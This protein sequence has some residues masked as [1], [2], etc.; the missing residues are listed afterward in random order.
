MSTTDLK[1]NTENEIKNCEV[2]RRPITSK[3]LSIGFLVSDA[4]NNIFNLE[5]G[6]LYTLIELFRNPKMVMTEFISGNRQRFYNPFRFLLVA[7]TVYALVTSFFGLSIP[8]FMQAGGGS[9]NMIT[10]EFLAEYADLII[11]ANVP[12]AALGS[13]LAFRP[14]KLNYSEHLVVNAYAYSLMTIVNIPIDIIFATLLPAL[15][16]YWKIA[17]SGLIL[18]VIYIYV[19]SLSESVFKGILRSMLAFFY[20]IM[21]AAVFMVPIGFLLTKFYS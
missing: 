17:S 7:A 13:W 9:E 4:L 12:F 18:V 14:A 3:R 5:R 2:C 10:Q 6:L 8:E 1:S 19:R 11:L 15:E 21:I 16:D 20:V